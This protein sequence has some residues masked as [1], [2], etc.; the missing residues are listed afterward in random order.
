MLFQK[1]QSVR[2]W[3]VMLDA[4][5]TGSQNYSKSPF[6]IHAH[7]TEVCGVFAKQFFKRKDPAEAA[8]FLPKIFAW[9][10]ALLRKVRP[11][12]ANLEEIILRK[13][14]DLCPYCLKKPCQCWKGEKP[15][16][17]DHHL[18]DAFYSNAPGIKRSLNDFQ[19][20]FREIY[21]QSW[22]SD[23]DPK[24]HAT[25]IVRGLF[26]RLI[27]E[28][29]EVGEALRFHHLYPENFE[30]ELADLLAWWFAI[31]SV[32]PSPNDATVL[33]E[34]YMWQAYPGHCPDCQM[35]PCLCR[36]GPVRQLMSRP[37]PGHAHR[38]D[39]LTSLLNQ[40]AYKEDLTSATKGETSAVS[41][42][43]CIR[44]DVDNF[45]TVNDSYGHAAG[46]EALR[47]IASVLRRTVRE[48]DRVYRISGDE[49]GVMCMNFTEEEAAGAMRRVC[50]AL[51]T[52]PVRW[53]SQDSK[54]Q[55]FTVSVSIG[56]AE[57][58]D[59]RKI[60]ATFEAAD[61]AAYTSKEAGKARVSKASDDK[62]KK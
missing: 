7:L 53:V 3:V 22:I 6:E 1:T 62:N 20:M 34:D 13:F 44:L 15:T 38:F 52:S 16:L 55:E 25:E 14:P 61:K 8:K 29:A 10:V 18:R 17:Q 24:N 32:F 41:P 50:A 21:G 51:A 23:L 35:V 9:Q 12:H 26:I 40:A 36:P 57:V 60:E 5:Y 56:V 11:D 33:A 4:I 42:I 43:A 28:V 31:V 45:K 59:P 19:L 49:F 37:V 48:R 27:E 39:S 47:H 46:D 58:S 54:V 30:N 2:E